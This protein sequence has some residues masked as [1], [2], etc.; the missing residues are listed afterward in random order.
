[1]RVGGEVR[2]EATVDAEG[3]VKD[4]HALTGNRML[5]VAAEEAVK[6]WKFASGE[7][8]STVEVSVNFAVAQ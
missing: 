3:K 6:Q 7:G 8:E 4:V 1:M 5:Q 2:L